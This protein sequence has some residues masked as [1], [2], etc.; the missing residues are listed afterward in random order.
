M[1]EIENNKQ[2]I[3]RKGVKTLKKYLTYAAEFLT[4]LLLFGSMWVMS[5]WGLVL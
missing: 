4:V 5:L 1:P 2:N 3:N